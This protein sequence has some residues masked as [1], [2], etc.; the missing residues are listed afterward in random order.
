ME[1]ENGLTLGEIFKVALKRIWWIVGATA[2]A[3]IIVVL[4][5]QLWYNKGA[6]T[7]SLQYDIIYPYS[8]NGK[9]PDGSD[10]LSAD[11]ISLDTLNAVKQRGELFSG[12]DVEKMVGEDD[13]SIES[14]SSQGVHGSFVRSF[15]FKVVSKYFKSEKQAVAFMQA[16]AT[17]PIDRVNE[18]IDGKN[19]GVYF[20]AYEN[21]GTYQDKIDALLSQKD[22]IVTSY[23]NLS[24][25]G[26]AVKVNLARL[27][28]IFTTQEQQLLC[29]EISTNLYV[30]NPERYIVECEHTM[31]AISKQMAENQ[32]IID[33]LIKARDNEWEGSQLSRAAVQDDASEVDKW[34]S[35]DAKIA[36]YVVK[37]TELKNQ[38]DE[39]VSTKEKAKKCLVEGSDEYKAKKAFDEKL[40][41]YCNALKEAT[42]TL[43]SVSKKIYSDNSRVIY[44]GNK[45]Q[46]DG[47]IGAVLGA[48]LGAIIGLIVSVVVVL[49]IDLP[50]YKRAKL[51]AECA[52][53][54]R[55]DGTEEDG[56]AKE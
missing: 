6:Q 23:E 28:N 8:D 15:K 53:N 32:K 26:D 22:Y 30:L 13:I 25:Y 14:T 40:E 34:N 11:I 7:Y 39:I 46:L 45:V 55:Q 20:V 36:E 48:V 47:G 42:E 35:Y 12:L 33:A 9:Y 37:N 52:A 51:L 31:E 41:G 17:Y 1:E 19:Y 29:D 10:F 49:I 38:Y 16:V 54:K 3:L 50:K 18:I 4:V 27:G 24:D 21:A 2:L 44:S 43:K 56:S 5:T